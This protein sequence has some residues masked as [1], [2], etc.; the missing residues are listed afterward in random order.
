MRKKRSTRVRPPKE[1]K[2]VDVVKIPFHESFPVHLRHK[3]ESGYKDCY[4]KDS[5]DCEKYIDRYR[6]K[7]KNYKIS[8]TEPK[9]E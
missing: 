9:D 1:V 5:I 8:I 6:L 4:F 2:Q 7:P 3:D